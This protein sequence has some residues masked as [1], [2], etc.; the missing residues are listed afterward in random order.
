M[1]A[2]LITFYSFK[3]GVGCTQALANVAVALTRRGQRVIVIDMALE[4]PGLY[5]FFEPELGRAWTDEELAGNERRGVIEYFEEAAKLPDDEPR[6]SFLPC[7]HAQIGGGRGSIRMVL[8]GRLDGAYPERMARLSFD[9]LYR[10]LDGYELVEAFRR[11]LVEADADFVLVDS[12]AG[13][14]DVA[15]VCTFQL[16]DVVVALFALHRQ[17]IEGVHQVAEAIER[18][19]TTFAGD[20]RRRELL[21]VPARVDETSEIEKRDKW[22]REAQLRMRDIDGKLLGDLGQRIPYEP[23]VAFGEEIVVGLAPSLL[24][25]A[26]EHLTE[27]ILALAEHGKPAEARAPEQLP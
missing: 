8:P 1:S 27:Q 24:S 21:L 7:A 19:R 17:G 6:L 16:P 5:R 3:G 18:A 2:S 13:M 12:R 25:E 14:N 23:R 22:V 4:S 26:Y 9:E 10:S 11:Q 15:G 20:D